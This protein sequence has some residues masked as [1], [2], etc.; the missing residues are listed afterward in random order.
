M[1]K[2][3]KNNIVMINNNAGVFPGMKQYVGTLG[4]VLRK[5]E[6]TFPYEVLLGNDEIGE[7][8]ITCYGR[9]LTVLGSV[10]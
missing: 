3:K 2:I 10:K 7:I 9:E 1:K 6:F 8:V 4:I 5:K